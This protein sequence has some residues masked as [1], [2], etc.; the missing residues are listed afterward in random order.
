M[1][2]RKLFEAGAAMLLIGISGCATVLTSRPDKLTDKPKGVRVYPTKIYVLV[3][4]TPAETDILTLP[5]V[6]NGYDVRPLTVLAKQDFKIELEDGA[7][8]ALTANQDSSGFLEFLKTAAQLAAKA[9]GVAVGKQ[10]FATTFGLK[11]GAY[12]LEGS[13]LTRVTTP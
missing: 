6:A 11:A 10:S 9:G 7:V 13:T 2:S 5:D 4:E 8:T 3:S 1:M 12:V